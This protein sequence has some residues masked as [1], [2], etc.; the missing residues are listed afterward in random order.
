[1]NIYL[2]RHG[3][4]E[5]NKNGILGGH[6][7]LPL[8]VLGEEQAKQAARN[9][10]DFGLQF[11]AVYCS[12]LVRARQTAAILC[13]EAGLPASIEEPL[14]IERDFGVMTGRPVSSIK[15]FCFP[16]IIE[17]DTGVYFLSP[18]GAETFPELKNR[19]QQLL[20]TLVQKH[21]SDNILLVTHGDIGKMIYAAYYDLPWQE[22]LTKFYFG[23]SEILHL[24]P[25]LSSNEPH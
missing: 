24:F 20:T 5:D 10:C 22:V 16:D 18:E 2:A 15:E 11:A 7:D 6:R 25:R 4:N 14:L 3:Q 13:A 17:T 1:M 21:C 23:N 8:T 19:A 9:I 12:P